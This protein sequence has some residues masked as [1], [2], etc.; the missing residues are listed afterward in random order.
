M[1]NTC[2]VH[3][4]QLVIIVKGNR[5]REREK[6]REKE[7]NNVY[8]KKDV[9]T[10]THTPTQR[11]HTPTH[12][13]TCIIIIIIITIIVIGTDECAHVNEL[14]HVKHN[15]QTITTAHVLVVNYVHVK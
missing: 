8:H 6:E 14:M 10:R 7:D 2:T 3:V 12:C 1:Y 13:T 5:E 15:V 4:I 11:T 9:H